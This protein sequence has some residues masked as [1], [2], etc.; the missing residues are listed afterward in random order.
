MSTEA[1]TQDLTSNDVHKGPGSAGAPSSTA[2]VSKPYAETAPEIQELIQTVFAI[3]TEKDA[4][5]LQKALE[6]FVPNATFDLPIFFARGTDRI[7]VL[8]NLIRVAFNHVTVEPKLVTVQMVNT[9]LGR[10]DVEGTVHFYP[11]MRFFP[12]SWVVP[13]SIPIHATWTILAKGDDDKII[14][15]VETPHNLVKPPQILRALFTTAITTSGM[16]LTA[17]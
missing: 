7:R 11:R 12:L 5:T 15:V 13:Q 6:R 10:I 14:S 8:S 4:T 2:A 17:W 9:K 1:T 16:V 3:Y